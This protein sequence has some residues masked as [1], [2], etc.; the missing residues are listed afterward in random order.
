MLRA[1]RRP[2]A[3]ALV[4]GLLWQAVAIAAPYLV[5]RAL[6]DLVPGAAL[7]TITVWALVLAGPGL[8]RWAGDWWRHWW[9]D[10]AGMR[11]AVRCGKDRG[12]GSPRRGT[13]GRGPAGGC[14]GP[15]P[16]QRQ[17]SPTSRSMSARIA[18]A[19]IRP[20]PTIQRSS[21]TSN[22]QPFFTARRL[23]HSGVTAPLVESS[24]AP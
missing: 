11:A 22:W 10:R 4:A 23:P 3:G 2:L 17:L 14:A 12:R 1:V 9:V 6:D 21:S 18:R 5:G 8:V 7:A 15:D 24:S 20:M 16:R 19:P 13:S